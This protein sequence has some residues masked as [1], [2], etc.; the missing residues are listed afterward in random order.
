MCCADFQANLHT[1][2]APTFRQISIHVLHPLSG[3]SP[4]MCCTQFQANLHTCAAP[5][6]RHF[7]HASAILNIIVHIFQGHVTAAGCR[8]ATNIAYRCKSHVPVILVCYPLVN[9][10]FHTCLAWRS[11][12]VG[13]RISTINQMKLIEKMCRIIK[14]AHCLKTESQLIEYNYV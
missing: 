12:F 10:H 5:T 9:V 7:K 1:C 14:L 8:Y 3:K 6:F 13:L 11:H 4:Y 2:A